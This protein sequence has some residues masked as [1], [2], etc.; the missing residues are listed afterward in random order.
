MFENMKKMLLNEQ[1][2]QNR[3]LEDWDRMIQAWSG[4]EGVEIGSSNEVSG[5][6]GDALG[7]PIENL[8]TFTVKKGP[9]PDTVTLM[10]IQ[11]PAAKDLKRVLNS[12]V[13]GDF[14]K[15]LKIPKNSKLVFENR[16]ITVTDPSTLIPTSFM[17]IKKWGAYVGKK[18][19]FNGRTDT[20]S[21]E[22]TKTKL[23]Q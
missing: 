14:F 6:T 21:Y 11:K 9:T 4:N 2:I 10:A 23:K 12:M 17:K 1:V 22:F 19:E 18:N 8:Y 3:A 5:T 13:G 15:A 20:W 7:K 16:Y